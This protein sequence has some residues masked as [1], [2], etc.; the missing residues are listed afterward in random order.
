MTES[1]VKSLSFKE[2]VEKLKRELDPLTLTQTLISYFMLI[3][4]LVLPLSSLIIQGF[5]TQHML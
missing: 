1:L 4:F 3:G 5:K 2:T